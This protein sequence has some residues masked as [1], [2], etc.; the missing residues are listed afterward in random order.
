MVGDKQVLCVLS[1]GV[2][3]F[4]VVVLIYKVIGDQLICIFVDYG[5]F[6]KGEVEGVMK[7]FSEGF[8]MNVIKVDVKD[9]F[10]NKLKGVFDF[11]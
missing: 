5:F 1:G 4:V 8:N 10:L 9:R 2:D 11:E 6:C 3:F 7:I